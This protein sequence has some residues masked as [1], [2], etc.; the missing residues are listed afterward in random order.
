MVPR[1]GLHEAPWI[2]GLRR[3]LDPTPF[4]EA[5]GLFGR[6]SNFP[7]PDHRRECPEWSGGF[8]GSGQH[9]LI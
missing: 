3:L 9:L 8:N 4:A 1:A 7:V 6:V 2:N 5:L